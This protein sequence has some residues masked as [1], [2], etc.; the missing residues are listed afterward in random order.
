METNDLRN[1]WKSQIDKNI[2]SHSEEE[3]NDMIIKS[4]RKSMRAIQPNT[5]LRLIVGTVVV[6]LI[7]R[8]V[9]K[10]YSMGMDILYSAALL[11]LVVSYLL[12]ERSAYKLNRRNPDIPVKEWLKY[13]I[14]RIEKSRKYSIKYDFLIYG[15]ALLLGYVFYIVFQILRN[16]QFNWI[17]VGAF[18]VFF[19]YI[20]IIRH[21]QI[22]NHNKTLDKLTELYKQLEE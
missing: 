20:L 12:M 18:I 6:F 16:V 9:A 8:I 22:K 13:R 19:V 14:D 17:S 3:L 2:Q 15:G 11:I 21:F 7:W 1:I 5:I 10:G 4:A